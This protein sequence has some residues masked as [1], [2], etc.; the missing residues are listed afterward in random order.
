MNFICKYLRRF[1]QYNYFGSTTINSSDSAICAFPQLA[2]AQIYSQCTA[3]SMSLSKGVAFRMTFGEKY[4][5]LA[6]I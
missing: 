3:K 4:K 1:L 6:I 2:I 5:N